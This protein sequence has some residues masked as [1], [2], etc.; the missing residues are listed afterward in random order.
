[1]STPV[2]VPLAFLLPPTSYIWGKVDKRIVE[3][4]AAVATDSKEWPFPPILARPVATPAEI[5]EE[6]PDAKC[7]EIVDGMKRRQVAEEIGVESLAVKVENLSDTEAALRQMTENLR[8]GHG[9]DLNTRDAWIRHLILPKS[10]GGLGMSTRAIAAQVGI[11]R[12]TVRRIG[13][14]DRSGS[15]ARRAAKDRKVKR[16]TPDAAF[17]RLASVAEE[18]E[19]RQES[20]SKYHARLDY[21]PENMDRGALMVLSDMLAVLI[22]KPDAPPEEP[23]P[24]EP[25]EG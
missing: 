21:L 3:K 23:E 12:E 5:A 9:L 13:A 2:T 15:K 17:E 7:F 11:S 16:W 14:N 8:H 25:E 19:E 24:E 10:K 18:C 20:L 4:Y 6:H 1:M 22:E